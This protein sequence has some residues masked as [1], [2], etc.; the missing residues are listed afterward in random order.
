[1]VDLAPSL[2][3]LLGVNLPASSQGRVLA[4]MLALP[5][6]TVA[7]LPG[8]LRSQQSRLLEAYQAAIGSS[9]PLEPGED[10]VRVYQ[11]ALQEARQLRIRRERLLRLFLAL[12]IAALPLLWFWLRRRSALGWFLGAALLYLALFNLRYAILDG[13]TYSLSS[14]VS[15]D[16]LILFCVS[17]AFMAVLAAAAL[18]GWLSRE[19]RQPPAQAALWVLDLCLAIVYTLA[20]PILWSYYLN[21]Y[22]ISWFMPDFP[23]MF[24]AFL[25]LIQILAVSLAAI[26][27]AAFLLTISL[28]PSKLTAC[29]RAF[30]RVR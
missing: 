19:L 29:W 8:A 1:M 11:S 6:E 22:L 3:A 10:I 13:R 28:T 18:F 17:T 14:V 23:S 7:V 30:F 24:L 16:D 12:L 4:E 5:P 27:L 20:L 25:S 15:A 21:G 26:L 2:A 9:A